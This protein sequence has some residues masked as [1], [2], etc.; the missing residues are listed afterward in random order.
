MLTEL[1]TIALV[2]EVD[3]EGKNAE[4]CMKSKAVY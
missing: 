1:K 2:E 4:P 3:Q